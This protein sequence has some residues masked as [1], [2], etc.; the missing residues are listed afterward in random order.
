MNFFVKYIKGEYKIS[1]SFFVFI[2][3]IIITEFINQ[4]LVL[5]L[6]LL[7]FKWVAFA[8]VF[9]LILGSYRSA[10]LFINLN[11]GPI[12]TRLHALMFKS[13]IMVYAVFYYLVFF[14]S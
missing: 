5:S 8:F 3:G 9:W 11:R 4:F 1:I 13:F 12:K 6:K 10:Q 7:F 2:I 14:R